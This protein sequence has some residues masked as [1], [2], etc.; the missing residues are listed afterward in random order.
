[1][2]HRRNTRPTELFSELACYN[3]LEDAPGENGIYMLRTVKRGLLTALKHS[4]VT[5]AVS[6]SSWRQSRL[7]ILCYHGISLADEH[8]WDPE[9]FISP[10]HFE[11]RL[12]L[13]QRKRF[14]V[15]PLDTALTQLYAGTLPSRS[16][17]ITFD[18]GTYDLFRHAGPLLQQFGYPATVYLTTF[19][20]EYP[21][22]VF[23]V[24]C[25]YMLWKQRNGSLK[26]GSALSCGTVPLADAA[27]RARLADELIARADNQKLSAEE[28]DEL[29]KQLA[30]QLGIDYDELVEKR[31]LQIM[32]PA[33]V[34][35]MGAGNIAI[36]LHTHRHRT[37]LDRGLF[38]REIRDN[39][40]VIERITGRQPRHFCYPSGVYHE[41]FFPWLESLG[42]VSGTTCE[43]GLASARSLPMR[44]PRI[45][46]TTPLSAIEFESWLEG[47]AA[48]FSPSAWRQR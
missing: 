24:I 8:Q 43:G 37:P 22:P 14:N 42:V 11:Q 5:K 9:L 2:Y 33:E 16:V 12:E 45:F 23:S 7:A 4:R 39:S 30:R 32:R 36:E 20:C 27:V 44:L 34:A 13:L 19:Y 41:S 17:A 29:A 46:D 10:S 31:I 6:R 21:R 35:Q 18:D 1:L 26:P 48:A 15:L 38:E 3:F 28:K 47:T 25:K 40:N